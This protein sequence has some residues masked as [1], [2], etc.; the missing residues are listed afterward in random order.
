LQAAIQR[1]VDRHE[2]LR[3]TFE[4]QEWMRV[5]QQVVHLHL[6]PRWKSADLPGLGEDECLARCERLLAAES[7]RTLDLAKG[8]LLSVLHLALSRT[9]HLIHLCLPSLCA[10]PW[11]L[12]QLMIEIG[13]AYVV[14]MGGGDLVGDPIQYVDFTEWQVELARSDELREERELARAFWASQDLDGFSGIALPWEGH[15]S[16]HSPRRIETEPVP[17]SEE[18]SVALQEVAG[19][20]GVSPADLLLASWIM[21]LCRLTGVTDLA[22]GVILDGRGFADLQDGLGPYACCMPVR[23]RLTDDPTFSELLMRI[24]LGAR[25]AVQWQEYGPAEWLAAEEEGRERFPYIFQFIERPSCPPMG[26][27]CFSIVRC[28][29]TVEPCKLM[30]SCIGP[31]LATEL[32]FDA[33][34]LSACDVARMG[35][36]LCAV[37][38]QIVENSEKRISTFNIL[39]PGERSMLIAFQSSAAERPCTGSFLQLFEEQARSFPARIAVVAGE[40]ELTYGELD[41]G[42][43]RLALRLRARGIGTEQRVA[44][45]ARRSP[46]MVIGMLGV[47][48]AGGAY[49]PLDPVFP[50]ERVAA[51]LAESGAALLLVERGLAAECP[52][53]Y[54]S[55]TM[56]LGVD[57]DAAEMA[58][59][60]PGPTVAVMPESLMYLLFTSGSTGRP[61][62]V[63]IEHRQL[64]NYLHAILE[65]LDLPP[66]APTH[67]AVLSTFAAD[68]GNTMIFPALATGGCLYLLSPEEA[69]DPEALAQCFSRWSIDCL[70]IVPSHL[71][72]LLT[73]SQPERILPRRRLVI[74]GEAAS[75]ALVERLHSLAPAELVVL[76]HYG[77]TET[78]VGVTTYRLDAA[79]DRERTPPLGRPLANVRLHLLDGWLQPVPQGVVGEIYIG[80]ANIARGYLG[81]P[82]ATAEKFIPDPF[83]TSPGARVYRTGDRARFDDHGE[84]EILGRV[85]DQ[86][87]IRGFRVELVEIE[88]TLLEH[89]EVREAVVLA[90]EDLPGDRR[91]TAYLVPVG[92]RSP[93][94]TLRSFLKERLPEYMVPAAFLWLDALPLTPNGKVDRRVLPALNGSEGSEVAFAPARDAIELDL[95]ALWQEVL[96]RQPIGVRDDFF[97]LGGHSLLAVRLMA[98]LRER[99]RR[100]VPLATLFQRRTV[101]SLASTLRADPLVAPASPLVALSPGGDLPAFF[102]AAPA[103]GAVDC[104]QRLVQ[105]LG[106]A[107]PFYGLQ[108]RGRDRDEDPYTRIEDMADYYLDALCRFQPH[109][110]YHL[111]GWSLGSLVA[112]EMARKL[113]IVGE[114]IALLAL[115]DPPQPRLNPEVGSSDPG[116]VETLRFF[117]ADAGLNVAA[118]QLQAL[119]GE[120]RLIYIVT[121]AIEMGLMP[122][123]A[124]LQAGVDYLRRWLRVIRAGR[125][126]SL[127][128]VPGPYSGPLNILLATEAIDGGPM[129]QGERGWSRIN[130]G[131]I[132]VY[133]VQGNH[134]TILHAPHVWVVAELLHRLI[135]RDA[136]RRETT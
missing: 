97:D 34:L 106:P 50:C 93:R 20:L 96:K 61:K 120:E 129:P 63:G 27:L 121:Q 43:N 104:Y 6:E 46:Q 13:K 25:A 71:A 56:F 24:E 9:G 134:N 26:S 1:V 118:E 12:G 124:G 55:R 41:A 113:Q 81:H 69:S 28:D 35:R 83:S 2:V 59:G 60:E 53:D 101:E 130:S 75:P 18:M 73:I 3:T 17:I 74:G 70:K 76:N 112:Y 133:P 114:E 99:L 51:F 117:A 92:D 135:A 98:L 22:I 23:G 84:M 39:S 102:C 16:E 37:L 131:P 123:G 66:K 132:V 5:P 105:H 64:Q 8:P 29:S 95:I 85:D 67:F 21:Y 89:P 110:P 119:V 116:E 100:D 11:T 58:T 90:R 72:A 65:R 122:A 108:A 48:K 33:S 44:I 62:G 52:A 32:R 79:S 42:T 47:L 36:Q 88:S 7:T 91:L 30:L 127:Q 4:R 86:V 54:A 19:R 136:L 107:H 125:L 78:T 49:V 87:K 128:Y 109:G 126:A 40:T 31:A 94:E 111:G 82:D 15:A 45:Y 14:L 77:P 80:G 57:D 115:I 68:L 103:H 38:A 10:D